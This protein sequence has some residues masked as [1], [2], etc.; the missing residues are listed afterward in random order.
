MTVTSGQKLSGLLDCSNPPGLL[1]KML[2]E[3]SAW[4][5]PNRSLRWKEMKKSSLCTKELRRNSS[6][7]YVKKDFLFLGI[8]MERQSF[9]V[10][11][12]VQL[13]PVTEENESSSLPTVRTTDVTGGPRTN[14]GKNRLGPDGEKYGINLADKIQSLPTVRS[15][16]YKGGIRPNDGNLRIHSDGSKGGGINLSDRIAMLP[17][18]TK[19]DAV[20]GSLIGCEF[21]GETKHAMK[22]EQAINLIPTLRA[23]EAGNY[24]YSRGNKD[25]PVQTLS[26]ALDSLPTLTAGSDHSNFT[27][28]ELGGSGNNLR[29]H[30]EYRGLKLQPA[31]AEWMM[32]FPLGWTELSPW[33]MRLFRPKSSRSSKQSQ[34]SKG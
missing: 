5:N 33:E 9:S 21:N 18:L 7:S 15:T 27:F 25:K 1:A 2:L 11:R 20:L 13:E 29:E 26:G 24:C 23:N 34:K 30:G 10:F 28:Q 22:L 16:D 19:E 3:S 6:K 4:S 31:F 8:P 32:G 14:D 17:T 12:L